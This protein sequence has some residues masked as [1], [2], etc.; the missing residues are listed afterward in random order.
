MAKKKATKKTEDA[1]KEVSESLESL[2]E[3]M[4]ANEPKQKPIQSHPKFHK[5]IKQ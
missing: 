5:F 2:E 3:A 1:L 4:K